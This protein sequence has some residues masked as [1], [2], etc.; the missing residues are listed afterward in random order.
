MV[1]EYDESLNRVTNVLVDG[2]F[3]YPVDSTGKNAVVQLFTG[4]TCTLTGSVSHAV[5]R[6]V[7]LE[8][9]FQQS[10]C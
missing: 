8:D 5:V 9:R 4:F 7:S 1:K 6:K 2:S 3:L 10:T